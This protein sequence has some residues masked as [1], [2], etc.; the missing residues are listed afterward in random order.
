MSFLITVRTFKLNAVS[1]KRGCIKKGGKKIV[2]N[3][4]GWSQQ[5]EDEMK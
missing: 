1:N 4:F 5:D 3:E 2:Y